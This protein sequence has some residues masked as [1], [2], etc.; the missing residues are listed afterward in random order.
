[1]AVSEQC[2]RFIFKRN[3][4]CERYIPQQRNCTLVAN[5][6]KSIYES[7]FYKFSFVRCVGGFREIISCE[8]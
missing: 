5:I 6:L 2:N 7:A 8:S 3:G 4:F 1:M